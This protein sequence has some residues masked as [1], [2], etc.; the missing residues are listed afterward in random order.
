MESD[1]KPKFVSDI[2]V[3]NFGN[4]TEYECRRLENLQH[5]YTSYRISN[6]RLITFHPQIFHLLYITMV[7]TRRDIF[8]FN[9]I[10][11]ALS[12]GTVEMLKHF[13][14]FYH[15]KHYGYEKLRRSY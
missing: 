3:Q 8:D 4:R 13:Y 15:K 5:N 11:A 1:D 9:H 14:A 7:D 2:F 10:D 6:K 12:K